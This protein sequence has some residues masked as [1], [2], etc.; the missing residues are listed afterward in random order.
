M[1]V[2]GKMVSTAIVIPAGPRDDIADTLDSVVCFIP[3]PRLIVIVDDTGVASTARLADMDRD[4][5]VMPARL[6]VPEGVFGGLWVKLTD[7][8][9][10][11]IRDRKWDVVLRMDADALMIGHGLEALAAKRF[12]D[13]PKLG[14][15]GA[16]EFGPNGMKRDWAPSANQLRSEIGLPGL[17]KPTLRSTLRLLVHKATRSGYEMGAH[18]LG[19]CLISPRLIE[20]WEQFGW[21]NLSVLGHSRLGDDQLMGLLSA[22]AGYRCADLSGPDDQM[23]IQWRG[24]SDSPEALSQQG[25]TLVHSVRSFDDLT[26]TEIRSY[27]RQARHGSSTAC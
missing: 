25:K 13:D 17:R 19:T 2:S 14:I 6:G 26:E 21:L 3:Q 5:R 18:A 11:V 23:A 22:A 10:F 15:L 9:R 4:I 7:A 27:F 12:A 1:K 16:Y 8:Y 24:L 20:V